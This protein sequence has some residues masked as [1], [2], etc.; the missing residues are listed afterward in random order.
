M[1]LHRINTCTLLILNR[2]PVT[3]REKDERGIGM[4]ASPRKL[5]LGDSVGWQSISAK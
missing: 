5:L 3:G 2:R 4:A 1:E